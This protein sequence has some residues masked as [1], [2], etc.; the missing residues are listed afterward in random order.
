MVLFLDAD[1]TLKFR[2][3]TEYSGYFRTAILQQNGI[4]FDKYLWYLITMYFQLRIR[5]KLLLFSKDGGR[6]VLLYVMHLIIT[7]V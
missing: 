7:K 1:N 6:L 3:M 2:K 4:I 5:N